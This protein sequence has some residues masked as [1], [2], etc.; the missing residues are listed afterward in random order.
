MSSLFDQLGYSFTDTS[1]TIKD[2]SPD[3]LDN[4]SRIP[5]L[6]ENWQYDDLK[7][8]DADVD[9]YLKNPTKPITQQVAAKVSQI[10]SVSSSAGNLSGITTQCRN[11]VDH[12]ISGATEFDPPILVQGSSTKY[13]AH[14]DRLSGL[15]QPNEDTALLPHYDLAIGIGKSLVYLIYQSDGVQNNAPILGSFTSLLIGGDLEQK[16]QAIINYPDLISASISCTTSDDGTGNTFTTCTSNLSSQVITQIQNN[17]SEIHALFNNRRIH[18]ENYY[19]NASELLEKYEE[20]KRY[21]SPGQ[22]EKE[23]FVDI[24]GTERLKSN[25][26]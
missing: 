20:M 4:L 19:T 17:L 8:G 13:I 11:I 6:L 12:T 21:K 26:P 10:L 9:N 18:D 5:L 22:T 15:V 14:C 3:V 2:F 16:N 23:L 1:G 24:I 7:N 25:L